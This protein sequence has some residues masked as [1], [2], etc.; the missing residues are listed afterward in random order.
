V[1]KET[2]NPK[3]KVAG[4]ACYNMAI[5]RE[6]NGDLNAALGWAQK[7]YEDYND[8]LA[9]RYTR[10]LENR[11]YKNDVLKMQEGK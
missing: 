9:I 6:V 8:K 2:S 4:R 10:I 3:M 5:I 7:S 1:E 11:R